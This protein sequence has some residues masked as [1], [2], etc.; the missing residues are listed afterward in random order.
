M[1]KIDTGGAAFPS[2]AVAVTARDSSG[3]IARQ[4]QATGVAGMTLRDWFAGMAMLGL[5]V[6]MTG[7]EPT[8]ES[9]WTTLKDEHDGPDLANDAYEFAD[10]MIAH[11]RKTEAQA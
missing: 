8:Y 7:G 1:G 9:S 3:E 10:A 2:M 11:K 4:M 6:R 5:V